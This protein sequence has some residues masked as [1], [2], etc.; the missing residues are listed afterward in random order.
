M[1]GANDG[2]AG[3][4]LALEFYRS[5]ATRP[6]SPAFVQTFWDAED[7][8]QTGGGDELGPGRR[9]AAAHKPA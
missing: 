4:A 2:A 8:G 6:A 9:H 3:V 7:A 5:L 1:L